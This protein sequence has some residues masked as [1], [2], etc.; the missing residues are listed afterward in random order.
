MKTFF[1]MAGTVLACFGSGILSA[2]AA[3]LT[4]QQ[5]IEKCRTITSDQDRL[6]CYDVIGV[7]ESS[8]SREEPFGKPEVEEPRMSSPEASFGAERVDK[9][10]AE[11]EASEVQSI[12]SKVTKVVW[13][14]RKQFAVYLD[15][16]QI[17]MQK[18]SQRVRLPE[19]EFEVTIEKG[20][21][22]SYRMLVPGKKSFV[23]V[24]RYK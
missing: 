1:L 7:S 14:P 2:Q 22:G 4:L 24:V 19:G 9:S 10:P 15:N 17:W 8:Y 3:E 11:K 13:S 21:L 5:K 20:A 16:G 6:T 12:T 23:R 18:D